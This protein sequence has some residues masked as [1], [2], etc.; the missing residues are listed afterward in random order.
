MNNLNQTDLL[1]S[2]LFYDVTKKGSDNPTSR[3]RIPD[4]LLNLVKNEL[5]K[6]TDY[7]FT[8]TKQNLVNY[9]L[10]NL[11]DPNIKDKLRFQLDENKKNPN[12]S[13]LLAISHDPRQKENSAN[14]KE[15]N[16]MNQEITDNKALLNSAVTGIAW[17]LYNR[18]GL[19][20]EPLAQNSSDAYN[21]LR[22]DNLKQVIDELLR[23]GIN[24]QDRQRHLDNL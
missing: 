13:K 8:I 10:L 12:L 4:H 19:D 23:A 2:S 20:N 7:S 18:M 11:L 14:K 9:A 15:L 17:L 24:E 21:K 22:S 6:Q 16:Q 5:Q 3:V 1:I